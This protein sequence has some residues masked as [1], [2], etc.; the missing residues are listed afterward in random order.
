[1][2]TLKK[3]LSI[4]LSLLLIVLTVSCLSVCFTASAVDIGDIIQFGYYP[5]TRVSATDALQ[6]AANAAAWKSYNY[7]LGNG[8]DE[9]SYDGNMYQDDYIQ[10]KD[11][12]LNGVKYR[13]VKFTQYRPLNTG[14][15]SSADHSE[16]DNN[17]YFPNTVYYFKF[18]PLKWRVLDAG[19]GLVLC[20]SIVDSQAFQNE[21]LKSGSNY[22]VNG[23]S[24][25]ANNYAY[26]SIR[27]W[28]N[29]KFYNTAFNDTQK[30]KIKSTTTNN[31]AYSSV[32]SQYNS[33][34][35][36]NKIFLL[37]YSEVQNSSYNLSASGSKKAKGT[38]YAKCQGLCVSNDSGSVGY[39]CWQ[40]RSP[41][42]SSRHACYVYFDS[43][44]F[45][46]GYVDSTYVGIRP[47]CVLSDLTSDISQSDVY[48]ISVSADPSDAGTVSGGVAYGKGETV[49]LSAAPNTGYHFL[50][51]YKG[52]S[53]VSSN[54]NYS[55]T[56]T[57][58]VTL[59]AK[60]EKDASS[61]DNG[62]NS[63]NANRC[64]WCG[65]TH[66]G[67]FFQKI[68]GWFHS[69]MAKIFGNRF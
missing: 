62:G 19:T 22:Y 66:D 58:N 35:T 26:S 32:Y 24:F 51:W 11:F 25:Y 8:T 50:G 56:V 59:T 30:A 21:V 13:A 64:H 4:L 43:Y 60:C 5:Q 52:D 54:A 17:G 45:A 49:T 2:K 1:M 3:S 36:S 65:K 15:T 28:L 6:N 48:T 29:N 57:E 40:L 69:I 14:Y 18:E 23:T 31:D 53:K 39:S 55:F 16:Q 10:Y 42:R 63:Q 38:D 37:S 34:S 20:D 27:T 61:S 47:A 9:P 41:G 68:I 33:P 44:V 12:F 46:D 67:N 7:Y